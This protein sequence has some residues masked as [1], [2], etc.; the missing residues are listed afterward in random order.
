MV[1]R[2]AQHSLTRAVSLEGPV[3]LAGNIL[4]PECAQ[5]SLKGVSGS[6]LTSAT[7]PTPLSKDG[8]KV[9]VG[10]ADLAGHEDDGQRPVATGLSYL[11]GRQPCL[12][13]D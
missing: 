4:H 8:V 12:E 11:S 9:Q 7:H 6:E 13:E 3:G 1:Q 2:I 10:M 5:A